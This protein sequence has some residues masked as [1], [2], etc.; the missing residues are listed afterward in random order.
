[1]KIDLT[2]RANP[3]RED[4]HD[5]LN[6]QYRRPARGAARS[7]APQMRDTL[8]TPTAARLVISLACRWSLIMVRGTLKTH[9]A[10]RDFNHTAGPASGQRN[11]FSPETKWATMERCPLYG[12]DRVQ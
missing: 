12:R 6:T 7:V 2:E 1:M 10:K 11:S 4:F 5:G 3:D 8:A 9:R